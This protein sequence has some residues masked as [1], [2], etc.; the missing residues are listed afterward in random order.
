MRRRRCEQHPYQSST[1]ARRFGATT[2]GLFPEVCQP[3]P[4][5]LPPS[6]TPKAS[7]P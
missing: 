1:A 6:L 2:S 7:H 3:S 4:Y 5:Y